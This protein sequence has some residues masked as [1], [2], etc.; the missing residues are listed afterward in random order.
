MTAGTTRHRFVGI[1]TV[2]RRLYVRS[3][4][5]ILAASLVKESIINGSSATPSF[6]GLP[7]SLRFLLVEAIIGINVDRLE[8]V[9]HIVA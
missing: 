9:D 3:L 4:L 1:L 7:W 6:P 2:F 5:F 8:L